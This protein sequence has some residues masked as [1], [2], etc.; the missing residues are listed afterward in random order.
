M[1]TT[2]KRSIPSITVDG[3]DIPADA[4]DP[5]GQVVVDDF[6]G[7]LLVTRHDDA[8]VVGENGPEYLPPHYDLEL[9]ADDDLIDDVINAINPMIDELLTNSRI[10]IPVAS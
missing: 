4:F 10:K 8:L 5:I 6:D 3:T 1:T 7:R 2:R 9:Q